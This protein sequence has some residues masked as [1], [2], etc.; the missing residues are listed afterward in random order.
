[1]IRSMTGFG[2]GEASAKGFHVIAELKTLNSR[3]LDISIRLPEILQDQENQF[4]EWIQKGVS[5]GKISFILTLDSQQTEGGSV[6]LDVNQ[7]EK[8]LSMLEQ[9]RAHS[10][11]AEKPTLSDLIQFQDLFKPKTIGEDTLELL[12]DLS[13]QA[14]TKAIEATTQM[15]EREGGELQKDLFKQIALIEDS[16]TQIESLA[17]D[18]VPEARKRLKERLSSLLDG[19]SVDPDRLDQEIALLAERIDINEELVRTQSHT[20]FFREAMQSEEP[21]GRRLNFLTQELNRE[22]NTIGSKS[23]HSD[24][25][26]LVVRCKEAVEQIREQVQN[27]E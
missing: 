21:V 14:T 27:V 17:S 3:Y 15:R 5:R 19:S 4:R 8:V 16:I 24:I 13:E 26:H 20:K 1:M 23:Y 2:R 9:I 10:G 12:M 6:S 25:S 11:I 18:R 22:L 7:L